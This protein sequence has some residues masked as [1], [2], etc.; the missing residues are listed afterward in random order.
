MTVPIDGKVKVLGK[1]NR[2]RYVQVNVL[3][4]A[5]NLGFGCRDDVTDDTGSTFV[6]DYEPAACGRVVL[7][8]ER[9]STFN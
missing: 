7:K 9:R 3:L 8:D 4:C 5:M 1:R 6:F 2:L